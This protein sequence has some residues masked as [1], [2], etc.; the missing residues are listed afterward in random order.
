MGRSVPRASDVSPPEPG[1]SSPGDDEEDYSRRLAAFSWTTFFRE[2]EGGP[3]LDE[4]R[5]LWLRNY[6]FVLVDSRTGVTDSGGVCTVKL[7]DRLV[8]VLTANQQNLDGCGRVIAGIHQARLE[9]PSDPARLLIL[10][11]LSRY[12]GRVETDLADEWLNRCAEV[13]APVVGD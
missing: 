13:F 4:L 1:S 7:P 10:P 2:K 11:V 12:D 9:D 6:D 8:F 3:W 5:Q